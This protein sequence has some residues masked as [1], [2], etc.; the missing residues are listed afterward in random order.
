V[1]GVETRSLTALSRSYPRHF[2]FYVGRPAPS[3]RR[4]LLP[5]LSALLNSSTVQPFNFRFSAFQ[6]SVLYLDRY[7]R[8]FNGHEI[9]VWFAPRPTRSIQFSVCR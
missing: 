7:L 5:L 1:F 4:L 3:I 8:G 6:F 2:T 9:Q